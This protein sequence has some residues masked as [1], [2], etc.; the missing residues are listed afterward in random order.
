MQRILNALRTLIEFGLGLL[1]LVVFFLTIAVGTVL[2]G[3]A[4]VSGDE[5][6][7]QFKS[8]SFSGI[9]T[10][11]H[12]LTIENQEHSRQEKIDEEKLALAEEAERELD[13]STL[14]RFIRNLESR[15]Y[16][17]LSRQLVNNMFG[18]EKSESGSFELEGNTVGYSTNGD[19]VSLTV[20]DKTGGTTVISVPVGDFYF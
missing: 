13:N 15:I 16:A 4:P 8:P 12:Y 6:R 14:S 7:H 5:M 20:T 18:E 9:G 1:M 3:I 11:A 19:T 17:E 2:I 10:S